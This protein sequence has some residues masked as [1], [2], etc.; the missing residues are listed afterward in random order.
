MKYFTLSELINSETAIKERINNIPSPL[1]LNNMKKLI[2]NV[3]DPAREALGQ[4]IRV[5]S[6]YRSPALNKRVG[7]AKHS[8]H[9]SGRAADIT[10]GNLANN[11]RLFD[12]LWQI[13]HTELI[14]ENGGSWIHVAL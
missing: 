6:G 4:P 12:I 1:Y 5:N 7:G 8:Y 10:T 3:L 11:K 14:W 2:E 13:P 9:L